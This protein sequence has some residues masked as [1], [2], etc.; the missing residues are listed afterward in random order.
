MLAGFGNLNYESFYSSLLE[1]FQFIGYQYDMDVRSPAGISDS[2][3]YKQRY[4][5]FGTF[6]ICSLDYT[7]QTM[8]RLI[9]QLPPSLQSFTDIVTATEDDK[10]VDAALIVNMCIWLP[11]LENSRASFLWLRELLTKTV[12]NPVNNLETLSESPTTTKSLITI[13][14]KMNELLRKFGSLDFN[15]Q[16]LKR[17][18]WDFFHYNHCTNNQLFLSGNVLGHDMASHLLQ[19]KLI[20]FPKFFTLFTIDLYMERVATLFHKEF[21]KMRFEVTESSSSSEDNLPSNEANYDAIEQY[22]LLLLGLF[23]KIFVDINAVLVYDGPLSSFAEGQNS[24]SDLKYLFYRCLVN[25]CSNH[26]LDSSLSDLINSIILYLPVN[27]LFRIDQWNRLYANTKQSFA[28]NNV[29]MQLA[30]FEAPLIALQPTSSGSS[31]KQTDNYLYS[32]SSFANEKQLLNDL[33]SVNSI[34]TGAGNLT[35]I[36]WKQVWVKLFKFLEFIFR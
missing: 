20:Q 19:L 28:P 13:E 34:E 14:E 1:L 23:D 12:A 25:I 3:E 10:P 29:L 5:Q 22:I 7:F 18:S 32:F 26:S 17:L 31:S 27:I 15:Y 35:W 16:L 6:G 30:L 11:R 2:E 33:P 24:S 9:N 21:A 36:K 8:W 4:P